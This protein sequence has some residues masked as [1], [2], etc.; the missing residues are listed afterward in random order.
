VIQNLILAIAARLQENLAGPQIAAAPPATTPPAALPALALYPGAFLVSQAV[1]DAPAPARTRTVQQTITVKAGQARPGPYPLD[2]AA[3]DQSLSAAL[4]KQGSPPQPLVKDADFAVDYQQATISF[5]GASVK[6]ASKVALEYAVAQI[7][8]FREFQQGLLVDVYDAS[9]AG[10]ER[11]AS[12]ACGIV[13]GSADELLAAYNSPEAHTE[14]RAGL[15]ATKHSLSQLRLLEGTPGPAGDAW[16]YRL[17]FDVNGQL[18]MSRQ[19]RE[20][21]GIIA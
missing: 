15:F 9:L 5:P 6:A 4:L 11:W 17:K 18:R 13:L 19:L 12:L 2:Y 1:K 20:G 14:Y 21:A 3:L 16:L 7:D 10:A 8:T